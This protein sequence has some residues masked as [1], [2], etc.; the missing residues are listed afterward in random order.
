MQDAHLAMKTDPTVQQLLQHLVTFIAE[1]VRVNVAKQCMANTINLTL[2]M[3][4]LL[5]NVHVNL[6]SEVS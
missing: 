3:G 4:S 6:R 1:G 2:M 5:E